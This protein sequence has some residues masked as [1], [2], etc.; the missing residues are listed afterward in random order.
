MHDKDILSIFL[1]TNIEK[2]KKYQY[3]KN[4]IWIALF[5]SDN[6]GRIVMAFWKMVESKDWAKKVS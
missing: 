2:I 5:E 4:N 1:S 3:Y 6:L